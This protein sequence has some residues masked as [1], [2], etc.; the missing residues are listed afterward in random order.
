MHHYHKHWRRRI[1]LILYSTQLAGPVGWGD[2][3]VDRNVRQ[4]VTRVPPLLN[5]VLIFQTD[6]ISYHG[7]PE[8]LRCPEGE[9]RKSVV[10]YYYT[11]EPDAHVAARSTN[12]RPRPQDG[13]SVGHDLA[14]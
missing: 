2:R 3:A 8:P 10:F 1:N 9:S 14:G 13:P 5:D 4:C 11:L 7:F 12:Y 6:D